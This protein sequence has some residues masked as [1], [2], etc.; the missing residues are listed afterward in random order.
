MKTIQRILNGTWTKIFPPKCMI[1]DFDC[2]H[3]VILE[4]ELHSLNILN[5]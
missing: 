5:S 1:S 3:N 4:E 2:V